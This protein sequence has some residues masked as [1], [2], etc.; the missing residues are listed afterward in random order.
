MSDLDKDTKLD[1]RLAQP[2][3]TKLARQET[4]KFTD[5]AISRCQPI[6]L[7]LHIVFKDL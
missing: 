3:I 5:Y 6:F 7:D 1:T 2:E 4:I